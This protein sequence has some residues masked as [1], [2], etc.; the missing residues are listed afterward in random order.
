M[1]Q[2][3]GYAGR[4]SPW[5]LALVAL[6]C[7][8]GTGPE[9]VDEDA[10]A[11]G[12]LA[13]WVPWHVD[14]IAS[15]A[16]DPPRAFFCGGTILDAEHVLTA[17]H[18]AG[19]PGTIQVMAGVSDLACG[20]ERHAQVATGDEP[21]C[22]FKQLVDVAEIVPNPHSD[23]AVLKLARPLALNSRTR[24]VE[25]ATAVHPF[26][27][28]NGHG[29]SLTE[30]GVV[31]LGTRKLRIAGVKAWPVDPQAIRPD[32]PPLPA[33]LLPFAEQGML[34]RGIPWN[35]RIGDRRYPAGNA[36]AGDSGS[37]LWTKKDGKIYVQ[38]IVL[39]PGSHSSF[40]GRNG[41]PAAFTSAVA[42]RDWILATVAGA[43]PEVPDA[44]FGAC[45]PQLAPPAA[46]DCDVV[47][48][49]WRADRMTYRPLD[50][51]SEL[52][53]ASDGADLTDLFQILGPFGAAGTVTTAREFDA[54]CGSNP[55]S[56]ACLAAYLRCDAAGQCDES[57]V[58]TA[59]TGTLRVEERT[60]TRMK[61]CVYDYR[62][63][64]QETGRVLCVRYA[65]FD[66]EVDADEKGGQ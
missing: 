40:C 12:R 5:A 7:G 6:G 35:I 11:R 33:H 8:V 60:G 3:N 54:A 31:E 36:C 30:D 32:M 21:Y 47:V 42:L 20:D 22:N 39:G 50:F 44:R 51:T 19:F 24:A 59:E 18:C 34:L 16:G 48:D 10:I 53:R 37:G 4:W 61:G 65:A 57:Y 62:A 13:S 17:A 55:Q 38:G 63:T 56:D 29:L 28:I 27:V 14:L 45:D 43:R 9:Q 49:E 46:E 15:F 23:A 26:S 66:A 1:R 52:S 41:D 2:R 58:V 64:A 25:V